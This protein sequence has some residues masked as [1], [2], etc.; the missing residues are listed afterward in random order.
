MGYDHPQAVADGANVTCD[1]CRIRAELTVGSRVK[2]GYWLQ[3]MNSPTRA[4]RLTLADSQHDNDI[5]YAPEDLDR[6]VQTSDQIRT[7]AGFGRHTIQ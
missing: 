4:R 2:A 1:V 3:A 5:E 7:I 6:S